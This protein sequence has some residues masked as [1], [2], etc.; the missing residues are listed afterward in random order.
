MHP[1]DADEL[2]DLWVSGLLHRKREPWL[3]PS[4]EVSAMLAHRYTNVYVGAPTVTDN[5]QTLELT[6]HECRLRDMTYSAPITV[7]VEYTRGPKDKVVRE[8]QVMVGGMHASCL[9][10]VIASNACKL[11]LSCAAARTTLQR[12]RLSVGCALQD[13]GRTGAILIG[14]IPLMLRSD[15]CV[16]RGRSE[17]QLARV[18]ANCLPDAEARPYVSQ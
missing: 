17:E 12:R 15:R 4:A 6:P 16:L 10:A 7:D 13:G 1:E 9:R 2:A 3:V 8:S 14:R 18:G 11:L 5:F